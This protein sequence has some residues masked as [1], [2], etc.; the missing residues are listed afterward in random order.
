MT[1]NF[2]APPVPVHQEPLDPSL[3]PEPQPQ[4]FIF[5]N[6]S[7]ASQSFTA[8]SSP[9][10]SSPII[11]ALSID[12]LAKDFE[13]EAIQRANLYAFVKVC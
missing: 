10:S 8:L 13:L 1:F 6:M 12:T 4:G 11:D 9:P 5:P 3:S 7:S 2:S